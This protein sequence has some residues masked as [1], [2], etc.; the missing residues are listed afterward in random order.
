MTTSH[1]RPLTTPYLAIP[2]QPL[3]KRHLLLP[4]AERPQHTHPL[5]ATLLLAS[6][7]LHAPVEHLPGPPTSHHN[8]TDDVD[9]PN[10]EAE[11]T[12]PLLSHGQGDGLDVELDEDAGDVIL[13]DLVRLR[14]GGVLVCLYGVGRVEDVFG[15]VVGVAVYGFEEREQ[16]GIVGVDG[17]DDGKVVLEFVEV[18]FGGRD[19]VVEGVDEFGVVRAEGQLLDLVG[20][21][22]A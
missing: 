7:D 10:H 18:V 16:R 6:P 14:G 11:E 1:K 9:E 21:V 2:S 15:G 5:A 4:I 19:G 17:R 3:I 13:G 8:A 20:E 22:E 12:T